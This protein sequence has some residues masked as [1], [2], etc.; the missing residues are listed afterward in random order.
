MRGRATMSLI[1]M[2]ASTLW[3]S[4]ARA[5]Q[6]DCAIEELSGPAKSVRLEVLT[7]ETDIGKLDTE[8]IPQR[9]DW[10]DRSCNLTEEKYHTPDF[11]DDKHPQRIDVQTYLMKSNMGNKRRHRVF[12]SS[13]KLLEETLTIDDSPNAELLNWTR[14]RYDAHGR[15]VESDYIRDDKV[16]GFTLMERDTK[17]TLAKLEFHLNG[18]HAPFPS[19]WYQDYKFDD[20]GN[21]TERRIYEFDPENGKPK[22]AFTGIEYQVLDY[23]DDAPRGDSQSS[24]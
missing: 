15:V 14:F 10:Y 19:T 7:F 22:R 1:A 9:E 8:R 20:Q 3:L 5:N 4:I 24:H 12:D 21:W 11:I 13:G 23:Y 6:T 17:G 2:L 16:D 18:N